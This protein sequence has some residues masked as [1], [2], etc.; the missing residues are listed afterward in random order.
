MD[1][2]LTLNTTTQSPEW[3]VNPDVVNVVEDQNQSPEVSTPW[4]DKSFWTFEN[5]KS[6]KWW[7]RFK[8][9]IMTATTWWLLMIIVG[10]I[11]LLI[12]KINI[13]SANDDKKYQSVVD[14]YK[15]IV[16][17][18][19]E[20]LGYPWISTYSSLQKISSMSEVN[21]IVNAA[22]PFIF[23][24]DIMVNLFEQFKVTILTNNRQAQDLSQEITKYG[25]I[26]PDVMWLMQTNKEKIP[27]MVS[28]HTLETVKFW[29][30]LK[31][32]SMLDTFLQQA[33]QVLWI[34]KEDVETTIASYTDRW[35]KYISNYL[36][37]CYLNPYERLPDCS[38]IG[39]FENYFRYENTDSNINYRWLAR[40]LELVENRLENSTVASIKMNFNR[41]DP[42]AKNLVFEVV[43]ST[44]AEDEQ[45]FLQKGVLNPHV[46]I[47]SSLVNLL[48]QSLFVIGDSISVQSINVR[49]QNIT[50]GNVQIPIKTSSMTFDLPLQNSS[51][52][53]IF[54]F[55]E[56][57]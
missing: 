21:N 46:F 3:Q 37:M 24:K 22:I 5:I 38:Q 44:L 32:F 9:H 1:Q 54:D 40:I 28:L 14:S 45:A 10:T 56:I 13:R 51:Q 36:S 20:I 33:A 35:E 50:I 11:F 6:N 47:L 39:D 31:L 34:S 57:D 2:Q 18:V 42:N 30:A 29:T 25:F 12:A 17:S 4:N 53:E 16:I 55:I 23:K 15:S 7:S 41:F 26:H 19:D 43:V 49:E 52:R 48:K 27:I 8:L